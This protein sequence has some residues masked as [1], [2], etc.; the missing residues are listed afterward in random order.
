MGRSF[1]NRKASIFKTAG[2]KSKI[3]SKYGLQLYVAAKNGDPDPGLNPALRALIEKA[4][5]EQVPAHVIEKA[6]ERPAA[7]AAM[8]LCRPA[9]KVSG[10][11]V[12][13]S[14]STA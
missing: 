14:S 5:R 12:A 7:L 9:T 10:P 6:L 1:E 8:T 4:K 13:R 2:Q 11:V 3:Y